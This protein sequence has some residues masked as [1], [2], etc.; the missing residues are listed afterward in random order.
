MKLF[1]YAMKP[2]QNFD[3][4]KTL[5]NEFEGVAFDMSR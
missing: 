2:L 3:L 5:S 1:F 4:L